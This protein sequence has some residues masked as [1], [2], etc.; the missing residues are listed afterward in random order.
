MKYFLLVLFF[1]QMCSALQCLRI[2]VDG[3]ECTVQFSAQAD[4]AMKGQISL[5]EE[6][7]SCKGSFFWDIKK[8]VLKLMFDDDVCPVS[9]KEIY[10]S[11]LNLQML[12]AKQSTWAFISGTYD[13][14]QVRIRACE[15]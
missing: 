15:Q 11:P 2:K 3:K 5:V 14:R 10:F 6:G 12:A 7:S 13:P 9:N 4:D 8:G 1:A